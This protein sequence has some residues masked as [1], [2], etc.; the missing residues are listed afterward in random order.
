MSSLDSFPQSLLE[1]LKNVKDAPKIIG[2]NEDIPCIVHSIWDADT[3]KIIRFLDEERKI[4]IMKSVRL[5]RIDAPEI[6][7][8]KK[9]GDLGILQKEAS[10]KVKSFLEDLILG[11]MITINIK[12]LDK[13]GRYLAELIHDGNNMSDMLLERGFVKKYDGGTKGVW[14]EEELN[15]IISELD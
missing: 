7:A 13:Y 1:A 9:L 5:A 15:L 6:T 14:T 12:S 4:P 8:K 10:K 2:A 11:K 3:I